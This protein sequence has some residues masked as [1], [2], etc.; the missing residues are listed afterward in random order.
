VDGPLDMV[1]NP[2][3]RPV[4]LGLS[5]ENAEHRGS[6]E[7]LVENSDEPH[8]AGCALIGGP[9]LRDDDRARDR[10]SARLSS[11]AD[12]DERELSRRRVFQA[13]ASR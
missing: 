8:A 5:L 4:R 1:L 13:C 6:A 7:L 11:T 9:P 3:R 10:Q 2:R 12:H